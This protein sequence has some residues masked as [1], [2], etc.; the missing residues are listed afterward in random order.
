MILLDLLFPKFC[1]GCKKWKKYICN[2]CRRDIEFLQYYIRPRE[3]TSID[4]VL[5]CMKYNKVAKKIVKSIKYQLIS[6]IYTELSEFIFTSGIFNEFYR[7]HR[8]CYLQPIP[9]HPNRLKI[10][11]FNQAQELAKVFSRKF[12][13]P[14]INSLSRVKDTRPQAQIPHK[15]QRLENIKGAFSVTEIPIVKGRTIILVDDVYTSGS[16]CSEAAKVLKN[17]GALAV[18]V[19]SLARD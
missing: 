7:T 1:V 19:W 5:S 15:K 3:N 17:H 10:R 9:L 18:Y 2:D 13:Y 16:T 11:G 8:N 6:D 14:I 12:N 4:G